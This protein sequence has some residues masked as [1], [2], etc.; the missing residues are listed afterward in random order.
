MIQTEFCIVLEIVH[1]SQTTLH[2]G[3]GIPFLQWLI[4]SVIEVVSSCILWLHCS[5]PFVS[6]FLHKRD[7][8]FIFVHVC[9]RVCVVALFSGPCCLRKR[10]RSHLR[11]V[12][13]NV[14]LWYCLFAFSLL[15][16]PLSPLTGCNGPYFVKSKIFKFAFGFFG[17]L[18]GSST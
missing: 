4:V 6:G 7:F 1:T 13:G 10:E 2:L 18:E 17:F 8:I 9:S 5:G 11:I 16:V 14:V 15:V 12:P 3:N